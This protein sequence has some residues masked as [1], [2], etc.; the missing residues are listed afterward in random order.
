MVVQL[1][2]LAPLTLLSHPFLRKVAHNR[3]I[4]TAIY[5]V[6]SNDKNDKGIAQTGCGL[7]GGCLPAP[8]GRRN[9][10]K[11]VPIGIPASI[12]RYGSTFISFPPQ[13]SGIFS[14]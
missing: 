9:P 12:G 11:Q 13:A 3:S 5:T 8:G 1:V 4:H 2:P 6:T 7:K 10:I 14:V